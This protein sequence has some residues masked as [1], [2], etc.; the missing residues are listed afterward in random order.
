MQK[1]LHTIT[2]LVL[3]LVFT[4][5][6]VMA[7]ASVEVTEVE[8]GNIKII[9]TVTGTVKADKNVNVPAEIGGVA[10]Q[11]KVE[12]GDQV[13]KGE[14][15]IVLNQEK[16]LVQ[17]KQAEAALES[18]RANYDQLKNGAT[19][20]ELDRAE[21]S[22]QQAKSTLENAKTNLKLVEE[23]YNDKTS[24]EQQLTSAESQMANAEQ[25]LASARQSL[26]QA[27]V[28]FNQ[29]KKDYERMEYLFSESVVTEKDYDAAES[30]YKNA[31]SALNTAK[32]TVEQA[33]ISYQAAKRSYQLTKDTYDNPTQLKQQLE[34][35]RSQVKNAEA[36]LDSAKANLAEVK[37]GARE[38]Q[39][40]AALAQ[41][42][43][44]EANLEQVKLN[45]ADTTITSPIS[46]V[47]SAVNI[48][49]GELVSA[50]QS[51]VNVVNLNHVYVQL[52]VTAS[53]VARLV[54][55]EQV[56]VDVETMNDSLSGE[57][58][59][60]SPAADPQTKNYLVKVKLANP[61]LKIKAGM[62]ADVA[63]IKGSAQNAVIVPIEAVL[64]LDSAHPYLYL[65]KDNKAVKQKI[66]IGITN[67]DE[68]EVSSGVDVGD[69]VIIK[70]QNRI[71]SGVEVKVINR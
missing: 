55:G 62:F 23:L 28:N 13:A 59:N 4:T 39:L 64:D 10:K 47:I 69:Q 57:I 20:E 50:G 51:V 1:Q 48:E 9:E 29:A 21:A 65:L 3:M 26:N 16:L 37:R 11:V 32:I 34:N 63:L 6:A 5:V 2:L 14:V 30:Q 36:G 7:A 49:E 40:R 46:G 44:A 70:G 42:R 8:Q 35:A 38:E 61:A 17:Q 71:D 15:L 60:I 56:K 24:L 27:Q 41:V 58:S 45:L 54:K 53:T 22:Y 43:Q 67:S 33:E 12:I 18:A 31:E 19:Q 25:Q 68:V 52:D 66:E